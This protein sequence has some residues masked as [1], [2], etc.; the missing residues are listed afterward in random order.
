MWGQ[1]TWTILIAGVLSG[2]VAAVIAWIIR[3]RESEPEDVTIGFLGP[4]LAAMYLLVLALALATEWQTIGSAQQAVGNEAVAVRQIYWAASGL[5]QPADNELKGQV[6]DYLSTVIDHDWPQMQHGTLDERS[7]QLLSNMG[8]FL[9]QLNETSSGAS[10][11]Q[12]YAIGQLSTLASARSQ[13]ESAAGSR[14]PVGVLAAVIITSLIVAVFPF[15]GGIKSDKVSTTIAILQ[16]ALVAV[17]VVVVFQLDNPFT[18]PLATTPDSLRQVAAL[19]G[20]Q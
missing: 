1:E 15:A 14:L 19:V 3:K 5:P 18:G 20:V 17:A 9:L 13:R 2:G 16:A 8:T 12:Q 4:S 11:A 6:R 7:D 10:N